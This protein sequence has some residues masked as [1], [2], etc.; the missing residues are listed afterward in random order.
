M[1]AKPRLAIFRADATAAIGA[2]HAARCLSLARSLTEAGWSCVLV[3]GC[4]GGDALPSPWPAEIVAVEL[5][6]DEPAEAGALAARWPQGADLLVVDHYHRDANFERACRPWARRILVLDDLANRPHDCDTLLDPAANRCNEDYAAFVPESCMLLL[7]PAYLPLRASFAAA[8]RS[9]LA[10]RTPDEKPRRLLLSFGATDPDNITSVVLDILARAD[11]PLAVDILLGAAA[12]HLEAVRAKAAALPFPTI[13]HVAIEDVAGLLSIADLAVGAGGGGAWE[14]C[15]LGL[16]SIVLCTASNQHA[17]ADSLRLT[18]AAVVLGDADKIEDRDLTTVLHRLIE[19]G[20]SRHD[21]ARAAFSLCDGLG[22]QRLVAALDPPAARDGAAVYLRPAAALDAE[23]LLAWQRDP[24]TRRHFRVSQIPSAEEHYAWF[25][26]RLMDPECLF[27]IVMHG[28]E[29]AGVLRLEWCAED[30]SYE[31]SI[32]VASECWRLGIGG[33]ALA[34]ARRLLPEAEIRAE[35]AADNEASQAL[36]SAAGYHSE[37]IWYIS[38]PGSE[39]ISFD[40]LRE[41]IQ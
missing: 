16:P 3:S 4:G 24:H 31:V 39:S 29:P 15:C 10:R 1:K 36:F 28:G 30:D 41:A 18:G 14:R 22:A 27:N 40:G 25:S 38:R 23:R 21:M 6:V 8:R 37:G 5:A 26:A 13:L 11:W 17:V 32:Y 19:D 9:A 2:G 34:L 12:P 7:G 33:A 20:A 35:V